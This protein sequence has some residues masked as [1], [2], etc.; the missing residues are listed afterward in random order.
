MFNSL[1]SAFSNASFVKKIVGVL[2]LL[3]L[4][5]S[6]SPLAIVPASARGIKT[7]FGKVD[8]VV[9]EP[10]IHFRLPI[11]QAIH[12]MDVQI[13]K[14]E[15]DGDAASKD[16]QSVHTRIAI[17]Y[18][19]KPSAVTTAFK[20]IGSSTAIVAD[21][22]ILPAAQEAVKAVT[23]KFTAEELVTKR[24]EVRDSIGALLR[25]KMERHG[26]M[27]DEF[28]IVNFS[29][30]KTFSEAI[31]AKVKAEQERMKA[32]R[33]LLRI[34]VEAKQR[35]ATARAEAE[36]LA[37]QRQQITPDLLALRRIENEKLA[38]SKWDG[39]LPQW[40]TGSGTPFVSISPPAK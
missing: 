15:G 23:A 8:D 24:T 1:V 2:V 25:E 32:E 22:I 16:L 29:F 20:E 13:Q 37:I 6:L 27:L 10:G 33:D 14:G 30:S 39:K 3:V 5:F 40:S 18:H 34:E 31:E 26:L 11:A 9:L 36:S 35:V 19:L 4:I 28:A 7:T 21:R 12:L 38:I 17:N